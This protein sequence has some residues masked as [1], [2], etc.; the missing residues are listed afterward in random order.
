SPPGTS[1]SFPHASLAAVLVVAAQPGLG[2]ALVAAL[3][4]AIQDQVV[5]HHELEAASRAGVAVIDGAAVAG[6]RADPRTLREAA[7]DVGAA[8]A[9]VVGDGGV[10]LAFVHRRDRCAR[11][12][13]GSRDA[14]VEVEVALRGGD[15]GNAPAHPLLVGEEL[16]ERRA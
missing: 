10:R 6:E 14:E 11:R 12:L 16:W 13:L 15:P 5:A 4:G 7:D 1:A 8:G 3:R 2:F 9:G